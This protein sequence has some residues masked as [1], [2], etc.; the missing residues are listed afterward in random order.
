MTDLVKLGTKRCMKDDMRIIG[1]LNEEDLK[2]ECLENDYCPCPYSV[3]ELERMITLV[4]A[5]EQYSMESLKVLVPKEKL[6]PM[7][8]KS[9]F[10]GQIYAISPIG[11]RYF[12]DDS[13]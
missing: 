11:E 5:M 9:V 12:K 2:K 3:K 7:L 6:G 13:S 4:R 10:T 1:I 8:V